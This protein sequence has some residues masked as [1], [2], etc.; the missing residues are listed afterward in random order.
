MY[1]PGDYVYPVDLPRPM[2]CRV[3]AAEVVHAPGAQFQILRLKPLAGTWWPPGTRLVRLDEAVVL[4]QT[5]DVGRPILLPPPPRRARR[6]GHG[7][8][9]GAAAA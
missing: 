3:V 5:H 9:A 7:G 6:A 8:V 4:A 1:Q 2:L